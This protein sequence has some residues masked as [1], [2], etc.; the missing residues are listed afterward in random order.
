MSDL[1]SDHLIR[2]AKMAEGTGKHQDAYNYYERVLEE[3]PDNVEAWLGKGIETGWLS[4]ATHFRLPEMRDC[5]SRALELTPE[6]ERPALAEKAAEAMNLVARAS[7]KSTS[8]SLADF[9]RLD[10]NWAEYMQHSQGILDALKFAH[11]LA[12]ANQGIIKNFIRIC[13]ANIQGISYDDKFDRDDNGFIKR[14]V[15]RLPREHEK[16][17]KQEMALFVAK[18]RLADPTYR[19]PKAR[20]TITKW[21]AGMLIGLAVLSS[22]GW[23][24]Y[25]AM[26]AKVKDTRVVNPG[27][28]A[29]AKAFIIDGLDRSYGVNTCRILYVDSSPDGKYEVTGQVQPRG[30]KSVVFQLTVRYHPESPTLSGKYVADSTPRF[31][32][33]LQFSQ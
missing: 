14:K 33:P 1:L 9:I 13:F 25:C 18:R 7:F 21:V 28:A 20:R 24:V 30:Q 27:V 22:A 5:V 23:A 3:H 8:K 12:P 6:L 2:L 19:P 32:I 29:F 31:E 16:V 26:P 15:S 17:F 11:E 10:D 4:N